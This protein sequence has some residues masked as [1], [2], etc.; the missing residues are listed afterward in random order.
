[1]HQS[2]S[3]APIHSLLA[4]S[5]SL[6]IPAHGHAPTYCASWART[7][8]PPPAKLTLGDFSSTTS[9]YLRGPMASDQRDGG[10]V[11]L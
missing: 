2:S 10:V 9:A 8:P 5:R 11:D 7:P 3:A 6:S 4:D 1:M